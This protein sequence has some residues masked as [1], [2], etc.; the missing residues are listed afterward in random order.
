MTLGNWLRG[1]RWL[2]ALIGVLVI[3]CGA[4]T[5]WAVR[6]R[7]RT[8]TAQND[9]TVVEQ[10]GHEWI[11]MTRSVVAL[12]NGPGEHADLIAIADNESAMSDKIRAAAS[13]VSVPALKDQLNKW[14][15]GTALSA[16]TQRDSANRPPQS[17]PPSDPDADA[18]RAAIITYEA[19][20]AL[21]QACPNMP[22][23]A[24]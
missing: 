14:A 5:I 24:S 23:T 13:S 1:K 19:T 22:R 21:L 7:T 10:L 4:I 9:C 16:K 3:I 15:R 17:N 18:Y 8:T 6:H 12:E 20:N 2:W 11:T